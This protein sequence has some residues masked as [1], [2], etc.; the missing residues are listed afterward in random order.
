ME[1]DEKI[2]SFLRQTLVAVLGT[3]G[4]EGNPHLA[5]IWF[6]WENGT[7]Y[8]FTG[9]NTV[10]WRNIESH[11]YASLCVARPRP[12]TQRLPAKSITT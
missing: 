3:V 6:H 5:P 11:P 9:R 8:M 10:K 2:D 12:N 7:A 1:I 4:Q